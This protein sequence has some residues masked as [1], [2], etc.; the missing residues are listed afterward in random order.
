MAYFSKWLMKSSEPTGVNKQNLG[1]G[2]DADGEYGGV[3]PQYE[4]V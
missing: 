2:D 1:N 3:N 4:T